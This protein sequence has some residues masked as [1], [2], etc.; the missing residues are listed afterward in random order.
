[1]K[2]DHQ[3]Y[4]VRQ[5]AQLTGKA[6][7]TIC[8]WIAAGKIDAMKVDKYYIVHE[9][10]IDKINE[11]KVEHEP[12]FTL[13]GHKTIRQVAR[14]LCLPHQNIKQYVKSGRMEYVIDQGIYFIPEGE[15]AKW[16]KVK[17]P[18][19]NKVEAHGMGCVLIQEA[20]LQ[21]GVSDSKIRSL[22]N[23]CSLD[24][25]KGTIRSYVT[26]AS[27]DLYLNVDNFELDL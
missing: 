6:Y 10:Q 1:M 27:I 23:D 21:L 14:I 2:S 8:N 17:A 26:Q 20:A 24:I 13:L 5:V 11:D 22:I 4:S 12:K 3:L 25:E 16:K 7:R 19:P 9:S 18:N 15:L